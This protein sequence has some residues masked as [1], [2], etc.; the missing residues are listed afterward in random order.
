MPEALPVE[1][2]VQGREPGPD[3][4]AALDR[5]L[6]LGKRDV[7]SGHD[8]RLEQA[9]EGLEQRPPVSAVTVRC[10]T[11]GRPDP[12]H[13]LDRCRRCD[14]VASRSFPHR[15]ATLDC[16]HDSLPQ[17]RRERR[18]HDGNSHDLNQYCRIT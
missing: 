13:Q 7:G 11:A 5:A 9:L 1:G 12:L 3:A 18:W 8:Q 17:V 10:R 16:L 14:T 15:T 2:V 4:G 6:E